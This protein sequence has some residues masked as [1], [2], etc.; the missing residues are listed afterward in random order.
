MSIDTLTLNLRSRQH[1]IRSSASSPKND[2]NILQHN[3][4][5]SGLQ[6][7][8]QNHRTD[9]ESLRHPA[10]CQTQR[11][12][13]S[14]T[15]AGNMRNGEGQHSARYHNGLFMTFIPITRSNTTTMA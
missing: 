13:D 5:L 3:A 4:L 7:E 8:Q 11:S 1:D 15:A 9:T 12:R 6:Y 10:V 2:G 14:E